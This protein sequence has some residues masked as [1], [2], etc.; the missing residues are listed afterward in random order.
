LIAEPSFGEWGIVGGEL[1]RAAGWLASNADTVAKAASLFPMFKAIRQSRPGSGWFQSLEDILKYSGGWE[2]YPVRNFIRTMHDHMPHSRLVDEEFIKI[3]S[4]KGHIEV[5]DH[6]G[7]VGGHPNA[8]EVY[9]KGDIDPHDL[10]SLV[11]L[12][13]AME[14]PILSDAR[15]IGNLEYATRLGF[16]QE[17]IGNRLER[18]PVSEIPE[19]WYSEMRWRLMPDDATE[20]RR[21]AGFEEGNIRD[22]LLTVVGDSPI[23]EE[24][25]VAWFERIMEPNDGPNAWSHVIN[26]L[27]AEGILPQIPGEDF[28]PWVYGRPPTP[29]PTPPSS[30]TGGMV[31]AGGGGL[32]PDWER[33]WSRA[34][35]RAYREAVAR[36]SPFTPEEWGRFLEIEGV[37]MPTGDPSSPLRPP[38][39]DEIMAL[40]LQMMT[41]MGFPV[42]LESTHIAQ[43]VSSEFVTPVT[44]QQIR[45]A[46]RVLL[47]LQDTMDLQQ[48]SI[49]NI[50]NTALESGQSLPRHTAGNFIEGIFPVRPEDLGR[51]GDVLIDWL[52]GIQRT[53]VRY[54]KTRQYNVQ[55]VVN[56]GLADLKVVANT[57]NVGGNVVQDYDLLIAVRQMGRSADGGTRNLFEVVNDLHQIYPNVPLEQLQS[58][59]E[60]ALL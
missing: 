21:A 29:P 35:D 43:I 5:T 39:K 22:E 57:P 4:G 49:I 11:E 23:P 18:L 30:P 58:I 38:T 24:Q 55:E 54:G 2:D 59:A 37:R 9:V 45:D 7:S 14:L 10:A 46:D 33:A 34:F 40:H 31:P 51:G 3:R 50:L 53:W 28:G 19:Q 41:D 12:A 44:P 25:K 60:M 27:T 32:P 17:P 56:R 1:A 20:L 48:R 47:G 13:D 8:L 52:D 42:N 16:V 6:M 36:G 15:N 26:D